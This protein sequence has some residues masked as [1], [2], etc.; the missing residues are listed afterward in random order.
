MRGY[1]IVECNSQFTAGWINQLWHTSAEVLYPPVALQFPSTEKR[2]TIVSVGRFVQTDNKNHAR[3]LR[4]FREFCSVVGDD[5]RL[6]MIGFCADIPHDRAYVQN[7]REL[8]LGLPVTFVVNAERKAVIDHLAEAKLF[9]H[10]TGLGNEPQA[11]PRSQEHFGIA[12]VEAMLA[13]CVPLVPRG[14][15]QTEIVEHGDNGFL[16]RNMDELVM[17]TICLA[18]DDDMRSQMS[19]RAIDRGQ[20][21][22]VSAFEGALRGFSETHFGRARSQSGARAQGHP[23][24]RSSRPMPVPRRELIL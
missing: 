16:C 12:T 17:H 18:N 11:P 14:G 8:A 24:S 3:Q 22:N 15:G 6:Y 19:R 1:Q 5:W 7:L 9:W 2:N 4:A 20:C 23:P 13:G 21:F 10:A